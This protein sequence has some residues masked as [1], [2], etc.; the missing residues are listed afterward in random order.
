M[1]A[2]LSEI[3]LYP[4]KSTQAVQVSAS[5][6][7]LSGL[8]FDRTFMLTEPNGKF[9]TARKDSV[10]FSFSALPMAQ[11]LWV[12][13]QNDCA[14]EVR[15]QDFQRQETCEVWGN[16]FHA[17]IASDHINQW[18][19]EKIQRN[20]QLRWTGFTSQRMIKHYPEQALSF[21]DGY[22]VLLTN[23]ATLEAVQRQCPVP[24][25]MAQFRPN[26]V[27]DH[28]NAFSE[29][30]WKTIQI[31]SVRFAHAKPCT[32]C[33]LTTRNPD[34]AELQPEAEP[35]R[36]LKKYFSDAGQPIFGANLVPL[37]TGV[38]RLGDKLH[39]LE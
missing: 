9:I 10:L 4:I 2:T 31:G 18:F 32:R 17:Y 34:T 30:Q 1:Q 5:L 24:I 29:H 7:Q 36:T 21:A 15:Y 39:I 20:V 33:I 19:S 16:H 23:Q 27:I 13:Y 37:N 8:A 35:F 25:N 26:L 11:G 3:S 14:I 12:Q 22:P 28:V 38:V 6:V